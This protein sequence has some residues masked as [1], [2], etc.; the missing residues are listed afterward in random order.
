[1]KSSKGIWIIGIIFTALIIIVPIL[2]FVQTGEADTK[3]NP[4]DSVPIKAQ[5]TDHSALLTGPYETGQDVT[6]AC[7]ECHDNAAHQVTQTAHWT[8][9]SPPVEMEGHAE[10]VA[11]GKKTAI[12][13]FCI[14]IQGNWPKCTTCHVG[15]G[16][17]DDSFDFSEEENVDCLVCHDQTSTYVKGFAGNPIEGN[18]LVA[19]AQ[20][21]G[22]PTRE[23]CGRCHFRGGGGDAV[24]H[25]DLDE[26][27]YYPTENQDVHMG[28]LDF[29]CITCH[30]TD[31]H[32]IAG[33]SISV[34]VDNAN[35]VRCTDCHDDQL[36]SDERLNAHIESVACQTCHIPAGATREATKMHWDWST[37]GNDDIEQDPHVYLKIKGS[38]VYERNFTP[39]YAWYNG[40]ADRYLLGDTIDPTQPTVLNQP[41]GDIHDTTAKLWPFKVHEAKQPYDAQFNYL[42]APRTVGEGGFWTEFDWDQA[43][44]LGAEST[45]LPYS[46]EYGF[47]PTEMYWPTTHMVVPAEHALQCNDCHGENGRIDWI[48]LGYFGD[49]IQ[50]GGRQQQI[51]DAK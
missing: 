50:W 37:A 4:W 19:V 49:P 41:R 28:R 1:M 10:P 45:G 35:Q 14:G 42:I 24:K 5:H 43:F 47:A 12:N 3:K 9:E 51:S 25:G 7:V 26:S 16:W 36:H 13:N 46:G 20:S 44:I 11:I 15:Y 29:Q 22:S 21:V 30:R 18:D 33:R 8:W 48:A 6:A 32:Q 17:E 38:F 40:I 27:L 34:S 23:N 2:F 39:T 31:D